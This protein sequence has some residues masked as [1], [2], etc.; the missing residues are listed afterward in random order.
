MIE[1][2]HLLQRMLL[3]EWKG[4]VVPGELA[5]IVESHQLQ[6]RRTMEE[7]HAEMLT[8]LVRQLMV[9]SLLSIE[10]LMQI[11]S[12]TFHQLQI[13]NLAYLTKIQ[14]QIQVQVEKRGQIQGQIQDQMRGSYQ[15][16]LE[17]MGKAKQ[18]PLDT[19][20]V[21]G[22]SGASVGRLWVD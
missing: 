22:R 5:T 13:R 7:D 17:Q 3:Q 4:C 12:L 2:V 10:L 11:Q 9:V 18:G 1:M 20:A 19:F 14:I 8:L 6:E 15:E 21:V 16:P